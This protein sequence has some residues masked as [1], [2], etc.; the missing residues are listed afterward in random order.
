LLKEKIKFNWVLDPQSDYMTSRV[1][2]VIL[3]WN[4]WRDTIE[5][6]ESLYQI[7][8][9]DYDVILVDNGSKDE[10]LKEIRA[11][12]NGKKVVT[13]EFFDYLADNK[14]IKVLEHTIDEEEL[15]I[16]R[17]NE[18]ADLPSNRRLILIRNDKNYGFTEGNNI[19]IR[20]ALKALDPEHILLLNNDTVVKSD[21][22]D[23]LVKAIDRDDSIGFAGPIIYYY[24]FDNKSNIISSAG[25]NL[26][27]D[28]G[29]FQRVGWKEADVG[30]YDSIFVTDYLEGACLLIRSAVLEKIG[31]LNPDYFA[32]WEE[33]DICMRGREA[34]YKCICVPSAKIWHK[35]SSSATKG[36]KLY[37]MTRNRFWFFRDHATRKELHAFL[38][39]FFLRQLWINIRD[40]L[41]KGNIREIFIFLKGI[42]HGMLL[43]R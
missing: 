19:G 38:V 40:Y 35:V 37:Y 41:Y 39:Y 9:A 31:L 34:G 16:G 15:E 8:Y 21:F 5:C 22:L 24:N 3:N 4:G 7:T 20:Y 12:L 29:W 43:K 32:Y 28:K 36:M 30:Q 18:I 1:S 25:M 2:I 13:S 27:M 23:E 42:V 14:P 17:G 33:A 26:M 11:Y 6:L 10:S